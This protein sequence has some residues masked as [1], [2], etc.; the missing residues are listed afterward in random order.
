MHG[1]WRGSQQTAVAAC[2]QAV[3]NLADTVLHWHDKK[4]GVMT[5]C[6]LSLHQ[7]MDNP[8]ETMLH[9]RIKQ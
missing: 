3:L 7:V 1:V 8:A 9:W 2:R 6:H 5:A 4:Q